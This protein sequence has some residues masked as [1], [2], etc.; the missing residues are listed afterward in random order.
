MIVSDPEANF[1][2]T[3]EQVFYGITARDQGIPVLIQAQVQVNGGETHEWVIP[4]KDLD[5]IRAKRTFPDLAASRR[6]ATRL[7]TLLSGE[8][9][10]CLKTRPY[11][12]LQDTAFSPEKPGIILTK[13]GWHRL[14]SGTVVFAAGSEII[15]DSVEDILV[16][17]TAAG[18]R[19]PLSVRPMEDVLPKFLGILLLEAEIYPAVWVFSVTTAMLS[20]LVQTDV[21][22]QAVG[23]LI[24]RYGTGKSTVAE[25]LFALY[26]S[27]GHPGQAALMF[28]A[29]STAPALREALAVFR[30]IP[31][32]LDDFCTSGDRETVRLRKR[33]TARILRLAANKTAQTKGTGAAREEFSAAAGLAVTAELGLD[34]ESEW[35]RFF[36]VRLECGMKPLPPETRLVAAEVLRLFLFW[37]AP[38]YEQLQSEFRARYHEALETIMRGWPRTDTTLFV[39]TWMAHLF[40]RFCQEQCSLTD[41]AAEELCE[42]FCK[43]VQKS[44]LYQLQ[45]CERLAA[46]TPR[47][48]IPQLLAR[49]IR[50]GSLPVCTKKKH[51]HENAGLKT[52][53]R[54]YLWPG[55]VFQFVSGQQGY[56]DCTKLRISKELK[57]YSILLQEYDGAEDNTVHLEVNGKRRRFL[58]LDE[59]ALYAAADRPFAE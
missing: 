26:D 37:T 10:E 54:L 55:A 53:G 25:R 16:D 12:A 14:P 7:N 56:Q 41:Q 2:I 32:V 58:C 9:A 5:V 57:H 30:D 29:G 43:A 19:L 3:I 42:V 17:E 35:S 36:P 1:S 27:T 24:G 50:D 51:L 46:Q 23:Y 18:V 38:Q 15:G 47:E 33:T 34:S 13:T 4:P 8:L 22:F 59:K 48:S 45:Q 52:D 39:L 49:G 21:R 31:M 44:I 20:F 40:C 6:A 28:D 11:S